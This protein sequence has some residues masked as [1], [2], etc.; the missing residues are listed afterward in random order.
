MGKSNAV[1][2]YTTNPEVLYTVPTLVCCQLVGRGGAVLVPPQR[3]EHAD[4]LH[5]R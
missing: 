2:F 3:R 5:R 1:F 4:P